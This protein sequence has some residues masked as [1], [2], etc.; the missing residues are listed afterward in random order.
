[1][2]EMLDEQEAN[3][4]KH[5]EE[6]AQKKRDAETRRA[7]REEEA[8]AKKSEKEAQ[9]QAELPVTELLKRL[10]RQED[11]H[12]HPR[13]EDSDGAGRSPHTRAPA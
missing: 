3:E 11:A 9:R 13:R 1:M 2:E 6:V 10:D 8:A 12:A 5:K 7:E 4:K